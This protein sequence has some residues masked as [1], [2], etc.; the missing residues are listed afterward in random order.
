MKHLI[1][2]FMV[3]AAFFLTGTG[4]ST[5]MKVEALTDPM[6]KTI[7]GVPFRMQEPY[8]LRVYQKNKNNEYKEVHVVWMD[9]PNPNLLY[10]LNFESE[11]FSN[12]TLELKLNDDS[13]IDSMA[14]TT[15]ITSGAAIAEAGTQL[16]TI[17]DKLATYENDRRAAELANLKSK[18]NLQ[19]EIDKLK[20]GP[21]ESKEAAL[22]AALQARNDAEAA[23]RT[24]NDLPSDAT[25]SQRA[26]AE[27]NL[28]LLKL[29][30]NQAHRKAGLAEPYAGVFPFP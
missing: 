30:A 24:L 25:P 17:A 21:V 15:L 23:Q 7:A 2:L 13:T 10:A 5:T 4:C 1:L 11:Y 26:D 20:T 27:A 9:L 18:A 29:K 12:H 16:N 6:A 14:L 22:V 8:T 3:M 19:D 28:N